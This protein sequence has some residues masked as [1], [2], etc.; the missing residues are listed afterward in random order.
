MKHVCKST[1]IVTAVFFVFASSEAV[2]RDVFLANRLTV[3]KLLLRCI[4][5]FVTDLFGFESES[6]S[7]SFS[8]C[9]L[10]VRIWCL[11]GLLDI[12][13]HPFLYFTHS[14]SH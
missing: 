12:L 7:D 1:F 9:L 13:S 14:L 11:L 10:Y 4:A 2:V 5:C 8:H 6:S 3:A